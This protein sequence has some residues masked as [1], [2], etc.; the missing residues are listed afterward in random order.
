MAMQIEMDSMKGGG[1][2]MGNRTGS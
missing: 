1:Q 2:M